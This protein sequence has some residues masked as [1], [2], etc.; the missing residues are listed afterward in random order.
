MGMI[1]RTHR[2][3]AT[4][5]VA[6]GALQRR[7]SAAMQAEQQQVRWQTDPGLRDSNSNSAL[8]CQRHRRLCCHVYGKRSGHRRGWG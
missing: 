6:G 4:L 8:T 5:Q 1:E 7:R 3:V 2:D